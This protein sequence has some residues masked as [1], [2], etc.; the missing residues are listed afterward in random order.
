VRRGQRG[1]GKG[2]REVYLAIAQLPACSSLS[3]L[4]ATHVELHAHYCTTAADI[5]PTSNAPLCLGRHL[6]GM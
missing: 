5:L 1:I 6:S 2:R 4:A 3:S